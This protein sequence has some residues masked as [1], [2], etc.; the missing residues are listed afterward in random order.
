MI[1]QI[2]K[3]QPDADC[4]GVGVPKS[5][6]RPGPS[7]IAHDLHISARQCAKVVSEDIAEMLQIGKTDGE[8]DLRDAHLGGLEQL[9]GAV[10]ARAPNERVG[11]AASDDLQ[12]AEQRPS[13]D[14]HFSS[15]STHVEFKVG[16]IPFH[17]LIQPVQKMRIR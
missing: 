4:R 12:L 3:A 8:G 13:A 16:K 5:T 15:Q 2:L 9:S 10:Q 1:A 14:R 7:S 6:W 17:N 11:A